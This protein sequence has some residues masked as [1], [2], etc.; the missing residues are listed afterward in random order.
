M[1]SHRVKNTPVMKGTLIPSTKLFLLLFS[2]MLL[3]A[4]GAS[5]QRRSAKQQPGSNSRPPTELSPRR[6]T[7][8][9]SNSRLLT[10]ESQGQDRKRTNVAYVGNDP[11]S[12]L[13]PS[14]RDLYYGLGRAE[15]GIQAGAAHAFTDIMGKAGRQYD[16][17]EF[18]VDNAS[19]ALGLYFRH[20]LNNWFAIS[21]GVDAAML[22]VR[23]PE[24]LPFSWE[25]ASA[26][27]DNPA[28]ERSELLTEFRNN[29]LGAT[30][31]LEFYLPG[32][33]ATGFQ[34]Y[35]FVGIS[36]FMNSPEVYN[37]QGEQVDLGSHYP[38][39]VPA[40]PFGIGMAWVFESAIKVGLEVSY[41]YTG[42][43]AIDGVLIRDNGYD[44]LL[45]SQFKI[46]Y[47]IPPKRTVLMR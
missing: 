5:A 4:S 13:K 43:H 34:A 3:M 16:I 45:M 39:V 6:Q 44:S 7:S 22:R 29:F 47:L 8:P 40:L 15:V 41:R 2:G 11:R 38:G 42:E 23:N 33:I 32:E 1:A 18:F 21:A 37:E 14:A 30:G 12:P 28:G 26:D 10:G 25:P 36:A 20:R 19:P 35:G 27:P 46:G 9:K 24:G 31:K 17:G